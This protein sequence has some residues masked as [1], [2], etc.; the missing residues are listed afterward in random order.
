MLGKYFN[1]DKYQTNLRIEIIAGVTTF[2]TMAYILVVNPAILSETG[3]DS[4]ALFVATALAAIVGTLVMA[5]YAK[6]PFGLAPGMGLNAFFAYSVVIGMGYS[7]QFALTAV[8]IEGLIFIV[9]TLFNVR[10]AIVNAIPINMKSAVSV[11]IGLFIALIGLNKAGIVVSGEGTIVALGDMTSH[12][13]YLAALGIM[14]IGLLLVFRIRGAI[15]I[16]IIAIT[17]VGIPLGVTNIPENFS[18]VSAPPS[19]EP[20]FFKMNFSR[21]FTLD[22]LIVLFTF[23][24]VD[25]FDT[26]GTLI[27]VGTKANMI[28]KQGKMPNIKKALFADAIG[29]TAGAI[30][31]TSTTTTYIESASGVAEGGRTGMTA[32]TI[33]GLFTLALFFAPLF[34]II[35]NAATAPALVIVGLFM[36]TPIKKIDFEDYTEAIPAFL[37]IIMMPLA[38]SIAE[39]IVFGLLSYVI[40]KM[41]SGKFNDLNWVM[42]VLAVVFVLKFFV[43]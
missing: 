33:A 34:T 39:G 14:L 21:I 11:G 43:E 13:A 23:L 2:M 42:V 16:G 27:G 30:F 5:F 4:G 7:W 3:M 17:L 28:N 19:L 24:F 22:M 20:I 8:F 10:E 36:M 6:L 32:L 25:M 15:L 37:T 9:L 1:F 26:V 38:Y 29:T 35:P 31:G 18:L 41:V 12:S 40:L